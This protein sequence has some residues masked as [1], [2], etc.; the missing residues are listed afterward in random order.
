MAKLPA[1][2]ESLDK[3]DEG[4][5][6]FYVAREGGNDFVLDADV[7][8]HPTITGLKTTK[9]KQSAELKT[10]QASLARFK[11]VDPDRYQQLVRESEERD[12]AGPDKAPDAAKLRQKIE[13]ELRGQLEPVIKERDTLKAQLEKH[14]LFDVADAAALKGGVL[15]D[16]LEDARAV[17]ARFVRLT[18][19]KVEVLDREGDANGEPLE[20]F[21]AERFKE[22]KPWFYAGSGASGGGAQ[23]SVGPGGGGIVTLTREQ[24]GDHTTFQAALKKVGGDYSKIKVAPAT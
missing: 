12:A 16:R 2:I 19:G 14:Q 13:A 11:D 17:Y 3:V 1:V 21:F 8:S 18:A 24:A 5:R 15:P 20:K 4:A 9:A 22:M 23:G 7:E 6:G 10:L